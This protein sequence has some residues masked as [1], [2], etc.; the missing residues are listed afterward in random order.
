MTS[1]QSVGKKGTADKVM[2]MEHLE[3]VHGYSCV[4][5]PY[6]IHIHIPVVHLPDYL[7]GL[8]FSTFLIMLAHVTCYAHC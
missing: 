3:P 2:Y 6:D 4:T 1:L 7:P 8:F 5:A